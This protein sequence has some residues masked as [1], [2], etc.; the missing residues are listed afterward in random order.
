MNSNNDKY[1]LR[2]I[3]LN[4]IWNLTFKKFKSVQRYKLPHWKSIKKT[5]L[6]DFPITRKTFSLCKMIFCF[7][8]GCHK[9]T[10]IPSVTYYTFYEFWINRIYLLSF[11]WL[12]LIRLNIRLKIFIWLLY[13]KFFL[14]LQFC[15]FSH[16]LHHTF[17]QICA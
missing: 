14:F 1:L 10:C 2:N 16:F 12:I 17:T 13:R 8:M 3:R 4:E 15:I 9:R 7:K 5:K 6:E 11:L